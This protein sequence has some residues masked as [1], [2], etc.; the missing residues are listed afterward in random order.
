MIHL[1]PG[2]KHAYLQRFGAH[3]RELREAAGLSRDELA[4]RAG[5]NR[6]HVRK[7]EAGTHSPR[8]E[9]VERLA[10]ALGVERD[11][12]IPDQTIPESSPPASQPPQLPA[13]TTYPG[14]FPPGPRSRR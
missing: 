13:S 11:H 1:R 7:L 3:L 14:P 5:T 6:G 9:M 2:W 4:S 12:L 10:A 8:P